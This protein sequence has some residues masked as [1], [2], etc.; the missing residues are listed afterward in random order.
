MPDNSFNSGEP[1]ETIEPFKG[2]TDWQVIEPELLDRHYA[3]LH[4]FAQTGLC[5]FLPA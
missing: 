2:R 1:A 3:A 4:F 5:Y